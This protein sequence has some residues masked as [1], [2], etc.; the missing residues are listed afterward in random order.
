MRR[1]SLEELVERQA[2]RWE[3]RQR[4][5]APPPALSCVALSRLPHSG[6]SALAQSVADKLD[7]VAALPDNDHVARFSVADLEAH[8]ERLDETIGEIAMGRSILER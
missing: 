1:G 4:A 6:A 3:M 5:V 7:Y 8:P 2:R